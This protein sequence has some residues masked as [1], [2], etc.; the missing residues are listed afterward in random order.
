MKAEGR[1]GQAIL[2][3]CSSETT[4]EP[5]R[6]GEGIQ[7]VELADLVLRDEDTGSL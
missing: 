6:A 5:I 3:F 2:A 1:D 7:D 4:H